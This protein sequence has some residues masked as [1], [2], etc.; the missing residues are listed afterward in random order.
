MEMRNPDESDA[1]KSFQ[2]FRI[3]FGPDVIKEEIFPSE[4]LIE[5]DTSENGGDAD[6]IGIGHIDPAHKL[7][8]MEKIEARYRGL[9][10]P[11]IGNEYKS[12]NTAAVESDTL[13]LTQEPETD[14]PEIQIEYI[15][16]PKD[17]AQE[18]TWKTIE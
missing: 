18:S 11:N 14:I 16:T 12:Q 13:E 17:G 15:Q 8:R 10:E 1:P 2:P 5:K 6:D 7:D 4:P 9:L 3:D